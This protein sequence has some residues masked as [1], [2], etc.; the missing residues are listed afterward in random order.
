MDESRIR[1]LG[2]P[3]RASTSQ[4]RICV[5]RGGPSSQPVELFHYEAAKSVQVAEKVLMR[6]AGFLRVFALISVSAVA[7]TR[8]LHKVASVAAKAALQ[9]EQ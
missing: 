6:Y 3:D 4:A 9:G 8:A 7:T 1:V 5:K 2:Q